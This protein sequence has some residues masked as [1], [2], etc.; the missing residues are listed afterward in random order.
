MEF[1]V[2]IPKSQCW[3]ISEFRFLV[4]ADISSMVAKSNK[5][6]KLSDM[7]SPMFTLLSFSK[8]DDEG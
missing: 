8:E 3:S 6:A 4:V 5:V 7:T 1:P 2:L